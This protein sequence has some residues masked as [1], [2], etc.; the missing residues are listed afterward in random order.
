MSDKAKVENEMHFIV[1]KLTFTIE[2]MYH[3]GGNEA[4]WKAD[5][6]SNSR[7]LAYWI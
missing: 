6:L 4:V 1:D 7:D 5:V 3:R 2:E